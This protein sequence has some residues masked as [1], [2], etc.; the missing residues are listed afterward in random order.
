MAGPQL[1][2]DTVPN[3]IHY[4]D[5]HAQIFAYKTL[6][7]WG[8]CYGA[9]LFTT[10]A[11][12]NALLNVLVHPHDTGT[13]LTF[14]GASVISGL[15]IDLII[16]GDLF[17]RATAYHKSAKKLRSDKTQGLFAE[18][19][20]DMQVT[21]QVNNWSNV[22][23][24]A[25]LVLGFTSN[26]FWLAVPLW[27]GISSGNKVIAPVCVAITLLFALA[28]TYGAHKGQFSGF[29]FLDMAKI[30]KIRTRI[31]YHSAIQ[32]IQSA[33]TKP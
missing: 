16:D 25:A 14:L 4:T 2:P 15:I 26:A 21:K 13:K 32:Q 30:G 33:K 18:E 22:A 31:A 19:D 23:A 9:D 6:G 3:E 17:L 27:P 24:W 12:G 7:I 1:L 28:V 10:I 11:G 20:V 5:I 29:N 8:I